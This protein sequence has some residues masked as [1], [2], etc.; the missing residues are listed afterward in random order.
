[1]EKNCSKCGSAI[2]DGARF[3]MECG[4]PLPEE[5]L[6]KK[7]GAQVPQGAQF[8]AACGSAAQAPSAASAPAPEPA[9]SRASPRAVFTRDWFLVHRKS[10]ITAAAALL[11]IIIAVFIL[12]PPTPSALSGYWDAKADA[13]RNGAAHIM[14]SYPMNLMLLKSNRHGYVTSGDELDIMDGV[15]IQYEISGRKITFYSDD[16]QKEEGTIWGNSIWAFNK[17]F[18]KRGD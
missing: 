3:C 8:C 6:C 10:V 5:R 11:V 13:P 2:P 16:N 15:H 4:N 17:K 18:V 7:C 12:F 14:L 1:M 9:V